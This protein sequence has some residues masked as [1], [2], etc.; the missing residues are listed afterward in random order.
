MFYL[1]ANES[2]GMLLL[3]DFGKAFDSVAW[4]FIR[5]C[6]KKLVSHIK[7]GP[8]VPRRF[9]FKSCAEWKPL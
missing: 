3:I 6:Q 2:Y 8:D 4:D 9:D 7:R 5:L 1:E